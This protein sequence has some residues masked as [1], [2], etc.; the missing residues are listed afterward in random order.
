MFVP[1]LPETSFYL[2][3]AKLKSMLVTFFC[4]FENFA[5]NKSS[6][7]KAPSSCAAP[8]NE[9]KGL[10]TLHPLK[11]PCVCHIL[12]LSLQPQPQ[13]LSLLLLA[14]LWKK[15]RPTNLFLAVKLNEI[16]L[17]QGSDTKN[18][19]NDNATSKL[20]KFLSM[21]GWIYPSCAK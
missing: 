4:I 18:D 7:P 3:H 8:E 6:N 17:P 9:V 19:E 1:I 14:F 16:T 20:L 10:Q 2:Q 5:I 13:P 12:S 21:D 15:G 11:C